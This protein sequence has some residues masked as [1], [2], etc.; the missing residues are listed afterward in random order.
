MTWTAAGNYPRADR[1][2]DRT[3]GGGEGATPEPRTQGVCQA[4][5]GVLFFLSSRV[6]VTF[7]CIRLPLDGPLI[8]HHAAPSIPPTTTS[9]PRHTAFPPLFERPLEVLLSRVA[10]TLRDMDLQSMAPTP[11]QRQQLV[12]EA[13]RKS[14]HEAPR[15]ASAHGRP[16]EE[17]RLALVQQAVRK[18]SQVSH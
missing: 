7:R 9:G 14:S 8:H 1:T 6:L 17:A 12:G 4:S 16:S 11:E 15:R 10:L 2:R 18:S 13:R 5:P 3:D